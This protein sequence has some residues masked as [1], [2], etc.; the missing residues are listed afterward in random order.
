MKRVFLSSL[1]AFVLCGCSNPAVEYGAAVSAIRNLKFTT[2]FLR[3]FGDDCLVTATY[4]DGSY[5]KPG[6]ALQVIHDRRYE[7]SATCRVEYSSNYHAAKQTSPWKISVTE[8]VKAEMN[9]HGTA[10]TYFGRTWR[11]TEEEWEKVMLSNEGFSSLRLPAIPE[12]S[13]DGIESLEKQHG[14]SRPRQ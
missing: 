10:T 14:A 11:Y 9:S 1:L 13:G 2:S 7:V 6:A 3:M 8:I 12:A 4:Y 5:G